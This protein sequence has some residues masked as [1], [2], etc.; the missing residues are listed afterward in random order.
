MI[1]HFYF[2]PFQNRMLITNDSGNY[3]F[4]SRED[5]HCF[6]HEDGRMNADLLNELEE[7][8]FCYYDSDESYIR[9][10][11]GAIRDANGYLMSSTSLFIFAVT[12]AC[13]NRC[14]YCQANG[15]GEANQMSEEVA[16]MTLLRI[17]DSP[18]KRITIEFQGGEPLLNF[19][20][21]KYIF[22]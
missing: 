18:S 9:K 21:I 8:G 10:H 13:N 5:F 6:I 20:I 19:N 16:D 12:N 1:G 4:L 11:R 7:K 17:K 22:K 3:A 14:L 2:A 15:I